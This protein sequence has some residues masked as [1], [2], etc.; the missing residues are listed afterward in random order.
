MMTSET[1]LVDLSIDD[2]KV[3]DEVQRMGQLE[4]A[5]SETPWYRFKA[6]KKLQDEI[7]H[8]EWRLFFWSVKYKADQPKIGPASV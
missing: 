2:K 6:R 8:I 3:A 7:N 4:I 5:L 1:R